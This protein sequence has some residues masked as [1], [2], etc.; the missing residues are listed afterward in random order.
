MTP[1][2]FSD[3]H[4]NALAAAFDFTRADLAANRRGRLTARQIRRLQADQRHHAWLMLA[5]WIALGGLAGVLAVVHLELATEW[6]IAG[7]GIAILGGMSAYEM[8]MNGRKLSAGH[9]TVDSVM[10]RFEANFSPHRR[11]RGVAFEI[12]GREFHAPRNVRSVL[13]IGQRYRVYYAVELCAPC[14]IL[15]VEPVSPATPVRH[16]SRQVA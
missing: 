6:L 2:H 5:V 14:R 11:L 13:C 15:S 7:G 9:L 16:E 4:L 1:K 10:L 8:H 12:G 3:A